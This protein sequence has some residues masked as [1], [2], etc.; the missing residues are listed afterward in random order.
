MGLIGRCKT[1][2]DV[3]QVWKNSRAS[4][5]QM[6]R[7]KKK[8]P[9]GL[10]PKPVVI[11]LGVNV[12]L[13][14]GAA[15]FAGSGPVIPQP[16]A[17]QPLH[18][19]TADQLD[20]FF[21]GRVKYDH[22]LT[23]SE[24][25][26]PIFNKQSCSNCHNNPMGGTGSQTV[27]RF[28][29]SD[30]KSFD[31]LEHL[32]G[33][34]LQAV[35][36]HPDCAEVI[37]PEATEI[38]LRVTNGALAYGLVE[39]IPDEAILAVRDVQP[40]T[41]RGFAHMVPAFEDPEGSPLR[42]GRFGWKAQVPTVLTFSAD[43]SLNEMGFTNRFLQEENAPNGNLEQLAMCDMVP[44][45]EDGPDDE[46]FDFIDR[47]T[48]FQR[49]LAPFPQT[50]KSG[51]TGESVFNAIGCNVCHTPSF[52][53]SDDPNLEDAL[54]N[55]VIK[56][57][58]DFLL[59]NMGLS[60]DFIGQGDASPQMMK[61]PPLWGLRIRDPMWHDARVAGG[62]FEDRVLA[63]IALHDVLGSQ[64]RPSAQAFNA[65]PQVQKDQ[66]I[67]FLGSLGQ[68]EFDHDQNDFIDLN[69]FADFA[70]C[71]SGAGLFYT[72]DDYCAIHDIDQDG[73]VDL[74]DFDSFMLV[75]VGPRRD[76]NNNG[77][78]DLIDILDGTLAD[79]NG[80]GIPDSCEPT[81]ESD[82]NGNGAVDVDDLLSVISQWGACPGMPA[83]C[84]GDIDFDG[85]VDV[86]DL[87]GVINA[88]GNCP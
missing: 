82:V 48:D 59:H 8:K 65:L 18:D 72:P 42:V 23:E 16:K 39:A 26:G 31:P 22:A 10:L 36:I 15:V 9:R 40:I 76:C 38:A 6:M 13:V 27:T 86:S 37:P 7:A 4:S 3:R 47:V 46:G 24:G 43:A 73:D 84:S 44:D 88:W 12:P 68:A 32:G 34:L 21:K 78:I 85:S 62:S 74:T 80:N 1:L 77:V 29:F 20:R 71:Y 45:P 69:D 2:A 63:A 51:M 33:S 58:S 60:A 57:Y 41:Q 5:R 30:K 64:A 11:L 50:P 54:R 70:G 49:Y 25:L 61:T 81:C 14:L 35:S 28:G 75:Y 53:T 52:T 19:L 56:P 67:A 66:L 17:G 83:P 55:K 79:A 87:L